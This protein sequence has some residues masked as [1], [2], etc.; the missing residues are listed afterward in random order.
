MVGFIGGEFGRQLSAEGTD[1][2]VHFAL[3]EVVK[4]FGGK[5][6][7]NFIKGHLTNWANNRWTSGA[8]TAARPGHYGAR[9][10]LASPLGNR[11]FFAGEAVAVPYVT[12]CAGAYTSGETAAREVIARLINFR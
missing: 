1:T 7:D 2:A 11:L 6:R 9:A 12:L 10:E 4:M 3:D 8:Y 5:A